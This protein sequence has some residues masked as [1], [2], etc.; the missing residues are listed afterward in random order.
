M[1]PSV[2]YPRFNKTSQI[3]GYIEEFSRLT[4]CQNSNKI[5]FYYDGNIVESSEY[6]KDM[7]GLNWVRKN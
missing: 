6:N 3:D 2:K 5:K 4:K 1:R 7:K